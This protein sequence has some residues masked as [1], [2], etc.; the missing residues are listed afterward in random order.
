MSHALCT[1]GQHTATR[2]D[3]NTMS[4]LVTPAASMHSLGARRGESTGHEGGGGDARA[5]VGQWVMRE[6]RTVRI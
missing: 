6:G 1:H 2:R 3:I 5:A 4:E